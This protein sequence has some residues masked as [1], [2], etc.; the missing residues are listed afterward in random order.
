M[1]DFHVS[2]RGNSIDAYLFIGMPVR[3]YGGIP[4]YTDGAGWYA[5][6]CRRAGRRFKPAPPPRI[7]RCDGLTT[8]SR[9]LDRVLGLGSPSLVV[10]HG[11]RGTG[12]STILSS[13]AASYAAACGRSALITVGSWVNPSALSG[14][15]EA[16]LDRLVLI[17]I[18]DE[19]SAIAASRALSLIG[20]GLVAL[21]DASELSGISRS[22]AP[23]S[24]ISL[25]LSRAV[26]RRGMQA[27]VALSEGPS[28][29]RGRDYWWPFADRFVRLERLEGGVRAASADG[30]ALFAIVGGRIG[31]PPGRAR[32]RPRG[33][34]HMRRATI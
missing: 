4:I 33:R 14:L 10:I 26:H 7:V 31:D 24:Y 16:A 3:K 27:L 32:P 5:G 19:Q 22:A 9:A 15:P 25:S 20:F 11:G 1:L 28:G 30:E 17:R 13:A 6:A 23:Q 2:W 29:A 18:S 12:K 34:P 21:D 8:G